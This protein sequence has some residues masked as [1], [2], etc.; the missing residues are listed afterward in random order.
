MGLFD[1]IRNQFF[2]SQCKSSFLEIL[3]RHEGVEEFI[4]YNS[5]F[6]VQLKTKGATAQSALN[7]IVIA[8]LRHPEDSLKKT[9]KAGEWLVIASNFAMSFVTRYPQS[10]FS[11]HFMSALEVFS[12]W[13]NEE[14]KKL[15]YNLN[16]PQEA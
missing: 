12:Q 6:L 4:E 13:S 7:M 1:G 5:A 2:L 11:N 16:N 15:L 14:A 3:P 8:L 10:E 9:D